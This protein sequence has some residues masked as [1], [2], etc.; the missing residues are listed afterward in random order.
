MLRLPTSLSF[1]FLKCQDS[2]L[3]L[4]QGKHCALEI[5]DLGLNLPSAMYMLRKN[6]AS[7]SLSVSKCY[8][9][10]LLGELAG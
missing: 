7:L 5:E 3:F 1:P 9:G 8:T 10:C 4:P 2:E 6:W